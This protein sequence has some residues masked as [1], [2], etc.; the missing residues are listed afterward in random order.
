MLRGLAKDG[1]LFVPES[2][3]PCPSNWKEDWKGLRYEELA[4]RV[5]SLYVD[6]DEVDA[7]SLKG[8]ID[9]SYSSFRHREITPLYHLK[10]GRYILELWHGPTFA[11]K[12]VAL[13]FL[14]NLFEFFLQRRN[15]G[16]NSSSDKR[17]RLTVVGATSGD[18]GSAAIYGLRSKKDVNVFILFPKG[19]V[20]PIQEAQMTTVP[21]SN[22][23]CL[24]MGD[25]SAFDDCQDIVKALFSDEEFNAKMS[26]GA[27]NSINWARI[28][29]QIVY[30]FQAY[31]LLEKEDQNDNRPLEFVVPTG[32]F[33]DILAGYYAKKMGCPISRLVV[34]TNE[35]DIMDRF[36]KTGRY[37]KFEA[38]GAT[39]NGDVQ[40]EKVNGSTDGGQGG[41]GVKATL[42][43]AMDI[44]VSSNFE[45]L[46]WHL[47]RDSIAEGSMSKAGSYLNEWMTMVKQGA[48]LQVPKE[49]H[50]LAKSDFA[51]CRVTD[52]EIVDTIRKYYLAEHIVVDPHTAIG[53][54]TSDQLNAKADTNSL[55]IC[56]ATAHPAKFS[57]AVTL[58]LL[59]KGDESRSALKFDFDRDVL[60][61]ELHGLLDRE[62]RVV[63][64]QVGTRK[65][66]LAR[67]ADEIKKVIEKKVD[68]N[69][70]GRKT[71]I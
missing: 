57:E 14:G 25:D 28:L 70:N 18:T 40:T 26:L 16:K 46:L 64:V 45:R 20:S 15:D 49:V 33:G 42:S 6:R 10:D 63:N 69:E 35:N 51:S 61:V 53:L 2:I 66:D 19:K 9:R 60:P 58:S 47:A 38:G 59:G 31:F 13:Q 22:I 50:Q 56:L 34:A 62:R 11:F 67:L 43:P 12:D 1:G 39:T 48:S 32:N 41:G 68:Q 21:D 17:E 36:M 52:Q 8:L 27:I 44:L 5:I 55:Q 3:P 23:H 37:E 65:P 30:Y 4:Y 54:C 24:A 29:A 7:A 71:S